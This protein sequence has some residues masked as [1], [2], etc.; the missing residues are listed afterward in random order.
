LTVIQVPGIFRV[1]G[2]Q[3]DVLA[4]KACFD[5]AED[6][7]LS[8]CKDPHV[9]ANVLKLYLRELPNPLLTMELYPK[10]IELQRM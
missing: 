2:A 5:R 3:V 1:S 10:F 7:D 9:V 8:T 4:L 6:V